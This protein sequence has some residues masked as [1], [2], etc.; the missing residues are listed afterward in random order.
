MAGG[1]H[2]V[3]SRG[4]TFVTH[5][6]GFRPCPYDDGAGN[7]TRGYGE[8]EG[9][10]PHS[11][12]VT[13]AEARRNLHRRLNLDYNADRLLPAHLKLRQCEVDALTSLAYNEGPGILSDPHFSTLAK[14]LRTHRARFYR[15]RKRI[16]RQ[17]FPKW[18]KVNGQTWPGL[19]KR[20]AAELHLATQG[21]YSGRP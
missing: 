1:A 17:E 12:C 16:Y 6:E 2:H 5:W 4:V 10:G 7:W 21:D 18:V 9:I 15:Y 20:R 11:P 3:S 8:T 14:R 13:Q 19:V